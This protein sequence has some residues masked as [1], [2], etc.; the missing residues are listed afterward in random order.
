MRRLFRLDGARFNPGS[1]WITLC[2]DAAR[3]E[4]PCLIV[5]LPRGHELFVW[6]LGVAV[7]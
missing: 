1:A 5:R 3:T 7:Q 2:T 6:W 4:T